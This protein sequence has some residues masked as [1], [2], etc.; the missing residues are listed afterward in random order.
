MGDLKHSTSVL[1]QIISRVGRRFPLL[2][3]IL[4]SIIPF[5]AI[6]TFWFYGFS[7]DGFLSSLSVLYSLH[8]RRILTFTMLQALASTLFSVVVGVLAA[9]LLEKT[10]LPLRHL[11]K[12][13]S[14]V[15]FI[16]PALVLSTGV[17]LLF[18]K[19][20]LVNYLLKPTGL[21]IEILFTW[22]AIL[23]AHM[24]LNFSLVFRTVSAAI[25]TM[26][27]APSEAARTLGASRLKVFFFIELPR[28]RSAILSSASLVFIYCFMAFS[29]ILVLGQPKYY[30][31]EVAVMY[32]IGGSYY[33]NAAAISLFE[34]VFVFFFLA[35][36]S[37]LI[38]RYQV[39]EKPVESILPRN[40]DDIPKTAKRTLINKP[41]KRSN[42]PLLLKN[43]FITALSSVFFLILTSP[44]TAVI[45]SSFLVSLSER[46]F[47][48]DN[49]KELID[50]K[51]NPNLGTSP[52]DAVFNSIFFGFFTTLIVVTLSVFLSI[53]LRQA[54]NSRTAPKFLTSRLITSSFLLLPI[55]F[56]SVSIGF[57]L[58]RLTAYL[59]IRVVAPLI[60]IVHCIAAFPLTFRIISEGISR[61]DWSL[62][63]A[64]R[65]LG[66]GRLRCFFEISLPLLWKPILA[67]AVFAF[68]VSLGDFGATLMVS[69]PEYT[70]IPIAI[71]R[72]IS[73]GRKFGASS[74]MSA[75]L[76]AVSGLAFYLVEKTTGTVFSNSK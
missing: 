17:L 48:L 63:D 22:K 29:T 38:T 71:Y 41:A 19:N 61:F 15:M 75:I 74:A 43:I 14:V 20:G 8:F 13:I 11:F 55:G 16:L 62:V 28:L 46:S 40:P 66:A 58:V 49:Y 45:I 52:A 50:S 23:I 34:T 54:G 30:T 59:D 27:P 21:E 67:G 56:S 2:L 76:I 35:C 3:V 10:S 6:S 64:G 31:P 33:G 70:T 7:N 4:I 51:Y 73:A 44:L 5:T 68:A 12:S 37:A 53:A 69:S 72:F 57:G 47:T 24:L 1:K 42:V 39:V 32:F 36:S 26:D 25:S 60:L 9:L 18:G 65:N